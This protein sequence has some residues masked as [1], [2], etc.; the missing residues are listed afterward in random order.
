MKEY[1]YLIVGAGLFGSVIACELKKKGYKCLVIDKREHIGGNVFTEVTNDIIV[2]KYG[3]HIF[4][5]NDKNIWEYVNR[6]AKFNTYRHQVIAKSGELIFNLP[7]NMNTF[8]Q[9]WKVTTPKAALLK[10]NEQR[11]NIPDPSNLEEQALKLVGTDIYNK[12][13]KGYTEKQ[14]GR[15]CHQLPTFIIKRLPL[16]FT[17]CND[18]FDDKYQGIPIGGYTKLIYNLLVGIPVKLNTDYLKNRFNLNQIANKVIFSGPIDSFYDHKFGQLEYRSL[19]F[20]EKF[21]NIKNYQGASVVN[22]SDSNVPYSRVIEHKHFNK[23]NQ[24]NTIITYEYPKKY[25]LGD[26]PFYPI[27]DIKN[28]RLLKK[29]QTMANQNDDIIFGGRLGNYRYYDMH[30]I[31]GSA[32]SLIKK[33]ETKY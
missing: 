4:H 17:Y 3:A 24:P 8:Y 9:L 25:K 30:Q 22:Y 29:Y 21:I 14:W 2:H 15:P 33:I 20:K 19:V 32:L 10:I 27:N 31:I 6:Y 26:E 1:D 18:Y 16:R 5:T 28:E 23:G 13:I 7:F 12:L 11:I